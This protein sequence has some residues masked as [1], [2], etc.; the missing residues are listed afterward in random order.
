MREQ[1]WNDFFN[2]ISSQLTVSWLA[3]PWREGDPVVSISVEQTLP[4]FDAIDLL[5]KNESLKLPDGRIVIKR[6]MLKRSLRIIFFVLI[7]EV[8]SKLYRT[9][10]W[11]GKPLDVINETNL[12]NHIMDLMNNETL[13]AY[14]SEY[15]SRADFKED[16]KAI[17][18]LRNQVVHVNKKLE[19][20]MDFE[21]IVKRKRQLQKTISALSQILDLQEKG[22]VNAQNI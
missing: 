3:R 5:E 2:K 12:N 22:R 14:Q 9:Q 11:A 1:E 4:V 18:S 6:F 7:T 17:S 13:F 20:E 10:E 8:E 16:L 21:T 15:K 19:L